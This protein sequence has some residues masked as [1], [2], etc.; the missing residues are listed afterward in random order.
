METDCQHQSTR[1]TKLIINKI[2]EDEFEVF[3]EF[4]CLECGEII[5]KQ[6]PKCP[7]CSGYN[8]DEYQICDDCCKKFGIV[9]EDRNHPER[10]TIDQINKVRFRGIPN[11]YMK[12]IKDKDLFEEVYA[13]CPNCNSTKDII[14]SD[15]DHI[16]EVRCLSCGFIWNK[17]DSKIIHIVYHDPEMPKIVAVDGKSDWFDLRAAETVEMKAG[18]YRLISLGVSMKLPDGYEAYV[19]PRSSTFKQFGLLQTNSTGIIDSSFSGTNDIWRFPAYAM[20]DT[21]INKYDR[22]CQFRIQKKQPTIQF[23]EVSQLNDTDRG[24]LGSTGRN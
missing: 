23:A 4:S 18:E 12:S 13:V 14:S 7:V 19:V 20:R 16:G 10:L 24:G 11:F 21:T 1:K 6:I 17:N 8:R 2:T 22:I 3:D 5:K 9:G 15:P